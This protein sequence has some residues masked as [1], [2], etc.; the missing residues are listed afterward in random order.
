MTITTTISAVDTLR[1]V[2]AQT[3]ETLGHV[4]DTLGEILDD[5]DEY[6][7]TALDKIRDELREALMRHT[8]QPHAYDDGRAVSTRFD[9]A[10]G[11]FMVHVWHPDPSVET[12]ATNYGPLSPGGPDLPSPGIYEWATDPVTQEVTVRVARFANGG[13]EE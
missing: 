9:I 1:H 7:I 6:L 12:P 13:N 5:R 2:H 8:W 10:N 4:I 11:A 3:N